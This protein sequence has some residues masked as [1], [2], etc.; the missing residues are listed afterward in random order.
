ME[1]GL[2]TNGVAHFL[3]ADNENACCQF[4]N[5]DA[6]L[7]SQPANILPIELDSFSFIMLQGFETDYP[8][9]AT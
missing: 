2:F 8:G 4:G 3:Q 5:R 6:F 9:G 1:S 7:C